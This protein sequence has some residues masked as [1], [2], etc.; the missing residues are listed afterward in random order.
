MT[1]LRQLGYEIRKAREAKRMTQA[2]LGNRLGVSR[3]NVCLLETGG[4]VYPRIDRLTAI[5]SILNMPVALL[6]ELA[7]IT[8]VEAAPGQLA[9]LAGELD[10]LNQRRLIAIGH[11]LLQVQLDRPQ[12][13]AKRGAR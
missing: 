1:D 13:G 6:Y 9:W 8:Q 2:E 4:V 11:A 12:T 3:A 5:A 10:Q 7:G